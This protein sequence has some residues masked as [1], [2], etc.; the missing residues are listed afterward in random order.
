MSD[1][2]PELR[3]A[4][5]PPGPRRGARV[6][7]VVGL[8]LGVAIVVAVLLAFLLPRGGPA[9]PESTATPA[10]VSSTAPATP[11]AAP[12]SQPTPSPSPSELTPAKQAVDDRLLSALSDLESIE[13]TSPDLA[14]SIVAELQDQAQRISDS[15]P[16]AGVTDA[17]AEVEAYS[18][19]LDDLVESLQS[20]TD[21]SAR[22]ET[23]RNAIADL[24][25]ALRR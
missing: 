10:P 5:I 2:Q 18:S 4:P 3:W 11:S 17:H 25:D 15:L 16:G 1:E 23:A 6:W 8:A 19:S 24:R 12:S 22:A 13:T 21:V 9:A 14:L 20:G 7:L